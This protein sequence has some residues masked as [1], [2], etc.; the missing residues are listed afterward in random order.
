MKPLKR[1]GESQ[2]LKDGRGGPTDCSGRVL[3]AAHE[4]VAIAA[5][6]VIGP[7]ADVGAQ[8]RASLA[9]EVFEVLPANTIRELGSMSVLE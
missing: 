2:R 4:N 8:H 7:E 5:T 3:S 6:P 9:E 1:S